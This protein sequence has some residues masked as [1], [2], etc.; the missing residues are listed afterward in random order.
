MNCTTDFEM[1]L[2][3]VRIPEHFL[4]IVLGG[5]MRLRYLGGDL[6]DQHFLIDGTHILSH[7]HTHSKAGYVQNKALPWTS[8]GPPMDLPKPRHTLLRRI[9]P[10]RVSSIFDQRILRNR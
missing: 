4:P 2:I 3:F 5:Q 8:H 7:L 9:T 6:T 10:Q 1:N